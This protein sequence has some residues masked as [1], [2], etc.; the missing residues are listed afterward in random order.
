MIRDMGKVAFL[1]LQDLGGKIQVYLR[2]DV[3]GEE[4]FTNVFKQSDIGDIIGVSGTIM[5]TRTG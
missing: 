2:K 4:V 5:R 1:T 3:V